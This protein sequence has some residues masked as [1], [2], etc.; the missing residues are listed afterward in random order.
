[1]EK[2]YAISYDGDVFIVHR[3][4]KGFPD[5]VFK[6]HNSGLHV[7]NPNDPRGV[8]SYSFM[9][10]VERQLSNAEKVR[11]LQAGLAFPSD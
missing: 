11:N 10:I 8:A 7:Y 6:P 5:M 2:E 3:A 9:E 1:M 4:A